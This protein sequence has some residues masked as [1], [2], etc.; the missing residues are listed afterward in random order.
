MLTYLCLKTGRYITFSKHIITCFFVL[1]L[2][3]SGL[4]HCMINY[5][6]TQSTNI[7]KYWKLDL[8]LHQTF[9]DNVENL[10]ANISSNKDQYCE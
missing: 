3:L 6:E 1:C 2:G 10:I 9:F 5:L 8:R 7:D 4:P